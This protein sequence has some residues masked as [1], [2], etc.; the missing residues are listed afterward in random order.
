MTTI[1]Y[2]AKSILFA[3]SFLIFPTMSYSQT[4]RTSPIT[5]PTNIITYPFIDESKFKIP[6]KN[7]GHTISTEVI[8][9]STKNI[10]KKI[11]TIELCVQGFYKLFVHIKYSVAQLISFK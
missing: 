6:S 9:F 5:T 1:K 11:A 4:N 7:Y 2:Q 10:H 3:F 8:Q